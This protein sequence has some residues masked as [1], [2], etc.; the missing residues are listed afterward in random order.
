LRACAQRQLTPFAAALLAPAALLPQLP[1]LLLLR[2]AAA[3]PR[4]VARAMSAK[5]AADAPPGGASAPSASAFFAARGTDAKAAR[6]DAPAP[7]SW[8]VVKHAAGPAAGHGTY[9]LRSDPLSAP[10]AKIAAF[11]MAR[12][13]LAC[14]LS[15][16]RYAP[17]PAPA[18]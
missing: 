11:D 14:A 8:R 13:P 10:A 12:P 3:P 7:P 15:L 17:A 16:L 6:H 18:C 4:R 2:R 9:L 5:R 1:L